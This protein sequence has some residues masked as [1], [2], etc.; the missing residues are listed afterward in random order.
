MNATARS[1]WKFAQAMKHAR[2]QTDDEQGSTLVETALSIVILLAFIFGIM[3]TGFAL[4]TYHFIAEAAR[5]GTR[6]A[7]VRGSTC[8]GFAS[9]CPAATSD[10]QSY[11]KNLGFPGIDM[12]KMTVSPTWS[13]YTSGSPCSPGFCNSPGN[14]ITVT[15]NYNF[16]LSIPFVPAQTIALSSTSAMIISQ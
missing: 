13:A 11:V 14:L 12:S 9:A 2:H 16:P 10:I 15:V 6:Y 1:L 8:T 3:E 4:Y 7:I 5:E